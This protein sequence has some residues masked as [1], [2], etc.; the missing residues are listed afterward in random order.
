MAP[1]IELD[2]V[3]FLFGGKGL[4]AGW[5]DAALF[6]GAGL[7]SCQLVFNRHHAHPV[8]LALLL[9]PTGPT[10]AQ[11]FEEAG[12]ELLEFVFGAFVDNDAIG[13][14]AHDLPDAEL[15]GAQHPFAEQGHAHCAEHQGG[16]FAGLDIEAEAEHATQLFAR[17]SD[18]LAVD[19][20]AE[21][22]RVEALGQ[23][24]G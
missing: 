18:H 4:G 15:P 1:L 10:N 6:D 24:V 3:Q 12:A 5:L 20:L 14:A 22:L 2:V 23:R 9:L 11:L 16:E 21:A 17:F 8:A 13:A 19:H 7:A